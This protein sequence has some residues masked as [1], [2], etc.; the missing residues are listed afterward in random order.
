MNPFSFYD[1]FLPITVIFGVTFFTSQKVANN[2]AISALTALVKSGAF[3]IYFGYVFDG[4]YTFLDDWSYLEG[5]RDLLF[6]GIGLTNLIENWEYT[7]TIG[8]G[9]H[10]VYYLYNTYAF[11]LFGEGYYAP[12]ALNVI[13]TIAIAYLGARLAFNEF[14][15][16]KMASR[17]FYFYLL[18]HPN[19]LAWSNTMNGKDILVLLLHVILLT[20]ISMFLRAHYIKA[21]CLAVP[22]IL[23]LFFL[24]FYVPIMFGAALILCSIFLNWRIQ[25]KYLVL[26]VGFAISSFFWIGESG[27]QYA[28][29]SL[30]ENFVNPIYG[31]IRILLTPIPFHTEENYSFL[32]FP[33]LFHWIS[34]PFVIFGMMRLWRIKTQFSVFFVT[35]FLTFLGLYAV[36]GELQGPRHRIQLDY[37]LDILQFMGFMTAFGV[38]KLRSA[39]TR[40]VDAR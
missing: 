34:M 4:T 24:R 19:I 13:L 22:V 38:L 21:L 30:Q 12:V 14:E 16:S 37:A 11:R 25:F 18:L 10:F 20:I 39:S 29:S 9:D 7:L 6:Q 31:F 28:F 3:A 15:M 8:R 26:S 17:W 27:F 5:G 36:Y 23:T 40:V 33:A 32:N 2:I 35:Y 1:L